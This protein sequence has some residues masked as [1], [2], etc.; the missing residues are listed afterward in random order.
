M[1]ADIKNLKTRIKSVNSTYQLTKAM[2]LVASAKIRGASD[3]M[4]K[5]RM[6]LRATSDIV[7]QISKEGNSKKSVYMQNSGKGKTVVVAVA[8][9][10]GLAGGYN[11]NIFK[12]LEEEKDSEIIPIGKLICEKYRT[13][14]LKAEKFGFQDAKKIS[15]EL[16]Q[17]FR[18]G[19]YKRISVVYTKFLSM[20]AR[21]PEYEVV[22]PLRMTKDKSRSDILYEPD[23]DFILDTV[24]EEYVAAKI[25]GA[26]KESFV[27]ELASRRL[28]MESAGKNASEMID[29]LRLRY[30]RARQ[31]AITQ[32]ITEIVAGSE[33]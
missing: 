3:V 12:L 14:L 30:N 15:K 22:L 18:E 28:A 8:G 11:S 19:K 1:G 2:E 32:E 6:Y 25:F 24:I 33:S 10:R 16:C 7:R 21:I 27:S 20:L 23:A 26:V 17:G 31:G 13:E 9:D 4:N 5:A 29:D